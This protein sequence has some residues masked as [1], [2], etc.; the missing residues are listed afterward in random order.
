M[1]WHEVFVPR[2]ADQAAMT[3]LVRPLLSRP[4]VG[5]T[6]RVPVVTFEQWA[7]RGLVRHLI[8]VEHPLGSAFI[9]HLVSGVP[10]MLSHELDAKTVAAIRRPVFLGYEVGFG[11][12]AATLRTDVA[13]DVS[14]AMGAALHGSQADAT[15]VQWVVGPAKQRSTRPQSFDLAAELGLTPKKPETAKQRSAWQAKAREPLFAVR[16]R[17]ATTSTR[18]ALAGVRQ[19]LQIAESA[20]GRVVFTPSARTPERVA[21]VAHRRW[22]GIASAEELAVLLGWPL[23]GAEHAWQLPIGDPPPP[24]PR[25]GR[26]LGVSLHPAARQ[27]PVVQPLGTVTRGTWLLGPVGSGK[28]HLMVRMALADIA[29]GR[30]VVMV[31]P[32]GDAVRAVM[33]RISAAAVTRT[34]FIDGGATEH[35]V[36]FNPLAG[37]REHAER[38]ADELVGVLRGE[39]GTGIGPRSADVLLHALIMAARLPDGTLPDIPTI[40]TNPAFRRRVAAET[41]DPV[42]IGPWLAWFDGLSDPER[43]QVVAPV[44]NKLRAFLSRTSIRR[45]LGQPAPGWDFDSVLAA[46]GIVLVS[47]NRGVIGP[48]AARLLG[49]LLLNHLYAA[50]E[51]RLSQSNSRRPVG[52]LYI[53]EWPQ[54]TNSLDFAD[55]TATVRGYGIG[56]ALVNQNVGQIPSALRSV[57]AA[58]LRTL[59]TFAPG[60]D[61]RVAV[62]KLVG[63]PAVTPEDL[64][65]LKE[66]E[67]IVRLHGHPGATHLGTVA[68]PKAPASAE[69]RI[70]VSQARYGRE[71]NAIDAALVARW[72]TPPSG[73]VGRVKRGGQS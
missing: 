7:T 45:V 22:G 47:L 55:L 37:P 72:D 39:F 51:R 12:V 70:R 41:T 63:S 10:H 26:P 49:S 40:L 19:A 15:V 23:G 2:G 58:N 24:L 20:E 28:S 60:P 67:A 54:F 32:K 18:R 6:G 9:K 57:I 71:G 66:F 50:I 42:V 35:P 61:D 68:L 3:S 31:D 36:G 16:G 62:A 34:V 43:S 52:S 25:H 33:A 38:R 65:R 59:V 14:A 30:P 21:T 48:E 5:F 64:A 29:A 44:L 69:P 13:T 27:H 53:D 56:L 46:D 1:S 11:S 73:P 4:M 17:I 8:G